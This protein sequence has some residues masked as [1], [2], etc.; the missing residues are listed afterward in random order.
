MLDFGAFQLHDEGIA[1]SRRPARV[2][3]W[4]QIRDIRVRTGAVTIFVTCRRGKARSW[5]SV[6]ARQILN[7]RLFMSLVNVKTRPQ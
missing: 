5:A 6:Y 2:L 7:Y 4:P 1:K 3:P